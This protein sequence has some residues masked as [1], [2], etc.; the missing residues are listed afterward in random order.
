MTE[1]F[2]IHTNPEMASAVKTAIAKNAEF[3]LVGHASSGKEALLMLPSHPVKVAM[4]QLALPD[5]EGF[6]LIQQIHEKFPYIYIVPT[7][8]GNETGAVWQKILQ[9]NLHDVINGPV[10]VAGIEPVL[11]NA[12]KQAEELFTATGGQVQ[13]SGYLI[14]VASARG[15][16]GKSVFS[17][18]LVVSMMKSKAST[19]LIDYSMYAGDFFTMLDFVP[20][21]TLADAI[22]QG[23]DL[24][25]RFLSTLI[26]DHPLGFKFLACPNRD[27]DFYGF[28]YERARGLLK[29][30]RSVSDCIV[31]DTGAYDIPSTLAAIDE[32]DLTFLVTTRDLARLLAMQRYIKFLKERDIVQQKL[33]VIINN[34]EVG[35]EI[36]ETEVEDVLEHEVTAYLPSNPLQTTF[37]INS[38]KPLSQTQNDS[39]LCKV[40]HRLGELCIQR[41][42]VD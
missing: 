24:D 38:G 35:T 8:E 16:T 10:G 3:Q 37:S 12:A 4:V 34:A 22:A 19:C 7:L 18:N 25:L 6:D 17:T 5:M 14:A 21:N 41:W 36:S 39:P 11:R 15:G 2:L 40:I 13:G 27:F 31:V 32:S 9:L 23:G 20:R 29:I 26:S 28:D 33:K 30:S 42:Q 1:F